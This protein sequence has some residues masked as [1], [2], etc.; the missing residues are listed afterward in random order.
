LCGGCRRAEDAEPEPTLDFAQVRARGIAMARAALRGLPI[1]AAL[2]A[3][4]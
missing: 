3:M 2:T 1:D 4:V